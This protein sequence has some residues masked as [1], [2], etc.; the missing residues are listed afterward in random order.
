MLNLALRTDA[1]R[2]EKLANTEIEGFLVH[3]DLHVQKRLTRLHSSVMPLS[4]SAVCSR[5]AVMP[6]A[7]RE[8]AAG[9]PAVSCREACAGD[10]LLR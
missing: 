3:D 8:D 4:Q 6:A 2:L 7:V 5:R 9:V 10:A 1:D